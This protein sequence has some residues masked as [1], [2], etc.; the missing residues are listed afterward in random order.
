[1]TGITITWFLK[2]DQLKLMVTFLAISGR[3]HLS[4]GGG[5]LIR[6]VTGVGGA[7]I[8]GPN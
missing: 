6:G 1:M 5:A 4:V 2:G 8:R 3:A 7:L